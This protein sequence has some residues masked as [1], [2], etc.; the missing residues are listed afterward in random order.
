MGTVV[1]LFRDYSNADRAV[2]MLT[3]KGFERSEIGVVAAESTVDRH[4]EVVGAT[5]HLPDPV[6]G[7]GDGAVKGAIAG[8]VIGA[9]ALAIPGVGPLFVAGPLASVLTST[10]AGAAAGAVA[11]GLH[12]ALVDMGIGDDDARIYAEGVEAG[13]VL[14]TVHTHRK[15]EARD[16]LRSANADRV[17]EGMVRA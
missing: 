9:A 2:A 3:E 5:N 13:G 1:G 15:D 10:V 17:H 14:V 4:G 8:L 16:V 7:A 6:D 12:S 11:G